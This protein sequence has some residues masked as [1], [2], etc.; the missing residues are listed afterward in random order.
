MGQKTNSKT[1]NETKT[2]AK[3]QDNSKRY[4]TRFGQHYSIVRVPSVTEVING[5]PVVKPGRT[6]EFKNGIYETSDP[7][8]QNFLETSA[9][10]GVDY[11]E[12][13]K[14]VDSALKAKMLAEKEAELKA[15]EEDLHRR[16]IELQDQGGTADAPAENQNQNQAKNKNKQPK[17]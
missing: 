11:M 17:F 14:E 9:Y 2:A 13:T 10:A 5:I 8:E 12:V 1:K 15:K 3:S 4:A 7:D 6:I 16:E